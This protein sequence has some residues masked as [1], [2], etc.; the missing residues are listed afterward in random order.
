MHS[1]SPVG[2]CSWV[3]WGDTYSDR[4][5]WV[6]QIDQNGEIRW[7][8]SYEKSYPGKKWIYSWRD[9]LCDRSISNRHMGVLWLE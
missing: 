2:I 1:Q 6:Q 4:K 8:H 5:L 3:K 7:S 9:N